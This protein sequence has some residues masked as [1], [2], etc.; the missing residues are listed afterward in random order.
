MNNGV[1]SVATVKHSMPNGHGN[2]IGRATYEKWGGATSTAAAPHSS[3]GAQ[4]PDKLHQPASH[5]AR[6]PGSREAGPRAQEPGAR[7]PGARSQSPGARSPGSREPE[8]PG[9]GRPR[10]PRERALGPRAMTIIIVIM[11][12]AKAH[13]AIIIIGREPKA[14]E[15]RARLW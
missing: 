13:R 10:A 14:R 6:E 9:S 8:S 5:G 7:E 3:H 12:E 11:S 2:F 15:P 4:R 1:R